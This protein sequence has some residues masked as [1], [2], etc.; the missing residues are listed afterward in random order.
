MMAHGEPSF[1][2][3]IEEEYLLVDRQSR[4]LVA[5]PPKA[6]TADFEAILGSKV[7]A[8]F[9]RCQVEIETGICTTM[10]EARSEIAC[11]RR[12]IA[13]CADTYGLAPIACSTHPFAEWSDQH[14]TD[15]ARYN[16]L[17]GDLQL[18]ARR[19]LICG[20]HVHVGIDDEPLRFDLFN[21]L[22]YFLPHMLALSASSPFWRGERTGLHSYRLSVWNEVPRTGLPPSF[23]GPD[24]YQRTVA[25]LVKAGEIEDGTKIWWDL[26]PSWRF[27]TIEMRICD[28]PTRLDDAIAIAAVYR[29]VTRMLYRLRRNN[30][31]WRTYSSFLVNE[32]RWLAQR[33]GTSGRLIDFG[34]GETVPYADL[35]DE[36]I[37]F[38]GEDAEFLGCT[39]EVEHTRRIVAEG[40][41][42]ERQIAAFDRATAAG[43]SRHEALQAVVDHLIEETV[44]GCAEPVAEAAQ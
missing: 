23:S 26:R 32:N 24:E 18:L 13:E 4:D 42:A 14:H 1:T 34:K 41:S 6:L 19:L 21:Q 16:Q 31:R 43:A 37:A 7:T 20:M 17:A 27:P 10:Q 2:F 39:A 44:A 8:E 29:C 35:L 22:I 30:Q 38:I 12:N 33:N 40:T 5:D 36:L 15:K 28:V 3:G 9:L 11:L 25:A